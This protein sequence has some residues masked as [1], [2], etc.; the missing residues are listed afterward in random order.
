MLY[1]LLLGSVG[2]ASPTVEV[3]DGQPVFSE[4]HNLNEGKTIDLAWAAQSNVACFPG[5]ATQYFNGP[6]KFFKRSQSVGQDLII[7]VTPKGNADMS[8]YVLQDATGDPPN[9]ETAWRCSKGWKETPGTPEVM[10]ITASDRALSVTIGVTAVGG[11]KDGEYTIE[12]WEVKG[13]TF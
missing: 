7:R 11:V 4:T 1:A 9:V 12:V 5:T 13:R 8:I 6:H 3:P 10:R 2:F